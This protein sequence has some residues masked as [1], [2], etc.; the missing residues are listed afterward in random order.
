MNVMESHLEDGQ[1]VGELGVSRITFVGLLQLGPQLSA[2]R[3]RFFPP[4]LL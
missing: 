2:L 4:G 3:S 1:R